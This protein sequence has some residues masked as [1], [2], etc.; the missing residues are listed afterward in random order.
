MACILIYKLT[1]L[2]LS[3]R[4]HKNGAQLT[5]RVRARSAEEHGDVAAD[6]AQAVVTRVDVLVVAN[7]GQRDEYD[8]EGRLHE[9]PGVRGR[10]RGRGRGRFGFGL[11][12]G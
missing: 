5:L 6:V 3:T 9:E 11:G 10:G 4:G 2:P 7:A 8:N 12:L 1:N